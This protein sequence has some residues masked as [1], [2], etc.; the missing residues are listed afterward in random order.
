MIWIRII[1]LVDDRRKLSNVQDASVRIMQTLWEVYCFSSREPCNIPGSGL[2]VVSCLDPALGEPNQIRSMKFAPLRHR[3]WIDT[4]PCK[5][6]SGRATTESG[7]RP[8]CNDDFVHKNNVNYAYGTFYLTAK[9]K[10][11]KYSI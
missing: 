9:L 5:F 4:N 11:E 7:Y 2:V 10:S 3:S 8:T 1:L 6:Q